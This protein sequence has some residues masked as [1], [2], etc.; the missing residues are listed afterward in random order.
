[1]RD[2]VA[3][4][5]A[6]YRTPS[7]ESLPEDLQ[8]LAVRAIR[9]KFGLKDATAVKS[10]LNWLRQ[11]YNALYESGVVEPLMVASLNTQVLRTRFIVDA[12]LGALGH[13]PVSFHI[14]VDDEVYAR[15]GDK[16]VSKK[17]EEFLC[18]RYKIERAGI[19]S[20]KV[21]R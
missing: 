2:T 7:L 9:E 8:V 20:I 15:F 5:P 4:L 11:S 14:D 3:S 10:P 19:C 12:C 18:T 17:A 1:M 21:M 13:K 6:E 16:A